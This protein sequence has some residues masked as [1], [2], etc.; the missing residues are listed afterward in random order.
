MAV[1]G[2]LAAGVNAAIRV[3]QAHALAQSVVQVVLIPTAQVQSLQSMKTVMRQVDVHG[4]PLRLGEIAVQV[5]GQGGKCEVSCAH[6]GAVQIATNPCQQPTDLV[7]H[8]AASGKSRS[9]APAQLHVELEN[10]IAT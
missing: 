2:L 7:V 5:A 4:M 3:E 10:S 1:H 6:L 8:L 9:G